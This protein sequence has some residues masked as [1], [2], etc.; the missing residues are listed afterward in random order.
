MADERLI[1]PDQFQSLFSRVLSDPGFRRELESEGIG[2]LK[3]YGFAMEVPAEIERQL[4]SIPRMEA[5]SRCGT[6]GVCGLC[7]LC[8]EINL[9][10][11]S[12]FLW[13]TFFLGDAVLAAPATTR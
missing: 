10:S 12:A 3:K 2:T 7:S 11:G 5:T 13:A 4:N 8:G 9:G 1:S 6:C